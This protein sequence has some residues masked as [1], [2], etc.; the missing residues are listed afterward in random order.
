[1]VRVHGD[2]PRLQWLNEFNGAFDP[3]HFVLLFPHG[4]LGWTP[5]IQSSRVRSSIQLPLRPVRMQ[6]PAGGVVTL[7]EYASYYLMERKSPSHDYLHLQTRAKTRLYLIVRGD[8]TR[9]LNAAPQ[10]KRSG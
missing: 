10:A 3:L 4:E 8:K 9:G 6:K 1:M 2:R 5:D 7:R